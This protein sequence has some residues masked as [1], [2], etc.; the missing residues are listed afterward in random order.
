MN[1]EKNNTKR[2]W[3]TPIDELFTSLGL[4]LTTGNKR[5]SFTTPAPKPSPAEKQQE[6]DKDIHQ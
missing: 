3:R 5:G 6:D 1:T 2:A 4:P